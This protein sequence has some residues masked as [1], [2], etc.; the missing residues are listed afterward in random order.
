MPCYG[1]IKLSLSHEA[2]IIN[3]FGPLEFNRRAEDK[4]K[5]LRAL[6]KRFSPHKHIDRKKRS[7]AQMLRDLEIMHEN[8]LYPLDIREV[9]YCEGLLVDFGMALTEPS[10]VLDVVADFVADQE[11]GR[12]LGEFDEMIED[13]GIKTKVRAVDGLGWRNRT[14]TGTAARD[15]VEFVQLVSRRRL[16]TGKGTVGG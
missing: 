3:R 15:D 9:N 16:G 11:R 5:E 14:R 13:A 1:H 6:V 4:G 8:G 7:I 2:D 10:C 12:G